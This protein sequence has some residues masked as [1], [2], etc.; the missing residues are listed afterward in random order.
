MQRLRE[1]KLISWDQLGNVCAMLEAQPGDL[2][3]YVEDEKE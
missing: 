1:G 3:E 2:L